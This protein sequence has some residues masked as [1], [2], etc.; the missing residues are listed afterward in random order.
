M[1]KAIIFDYGGVLSHNW[2]I[3]S[4]A[5]YYA[6]KFNK[7][8]LKSENLISE[9]WKK[10]RINQI[11]SFKFWEKMAEFLEADQQ[12]LKKHFIEYYHINKKIKEKLQSCIIN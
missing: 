8:P 2:S 7:D 3:R 11:S 9:E 1:I 5:R 10:A 12:D 6:Q 4:F